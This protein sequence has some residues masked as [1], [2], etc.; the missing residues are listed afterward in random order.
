MKPQIC[1][2][3]C[4]AGEGRGGGAGR[5]QIAQLQRPL[6]TL[7]ASRGLGTAALE[8]FG[9]YMNRKALARHGVSRNVTLPASCERQEVLQRVQFYGFHEMIIESRVKGPLTILSSPHPVSATKSAPRPRNRIAV[10]SAQ[11][12]SSSMIRIRA[13]IASLASHA[14]AQR[15]LNQKVMARVKLAALVAAATAAYSSPSWDDHCSNDAD[16]GAMNFLIVFLGGGIG[17]ALRHGVNVVGARRQAQIFLTQ[18]W[19]L[20]SSARF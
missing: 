20:M 17:A 11:S 6:P 18:P 19:R 10:L 12:R 2:L 7:P 16:E 9:F 1:S 5:F 3:S 8:S 15:G 14:T 13:G 4:E